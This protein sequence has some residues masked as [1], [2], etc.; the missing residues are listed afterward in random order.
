MKKILVTLAI[1]AIVG[2][3]LFA[4][5]VKVTASNE[6]YSETVYKEANGDDPMA[7]R[8]EV[9]RGF[10]GF[11]E[12]A[13]GHV[14]TETWTLQARLRVWLW[15]L[16]KTTNVGIAGTGAQ[17]ESVNGDN[18]E[19]VFFNDAAFNGTAKNGVRVNFWYRPLA[20]IE[21]GIGN[22]FDNYYQ[23]PAG[24]MLGIDRVMG[25]MINIKAATGVSTN[26]AG[27]VTA[28]T[29]GYNFA[30]G[31]AR[32]FEGNNADG[33][34]WAPNGF[35]LN[36]TKVPNL[37][38]S[39]NIPFSAFVDEYDFAPAI[40]L[41]AHYTIGDNVNIGA[42]YHGGINRDQGHVLGAYGQF[43]NGTVRIPLGVTFGFKASKNQTSWVD[44]ADKARMQID[45]A[46]DFSFRN[47]MQLGISFSWAMMF[48]GTLNLDDN[49]S[50][51]MFGQSN[52]AV[53]A[54]RVMPLVIGLYYKWPINNAW[55]F[56]VRTWFEMALGTDAKADLL[57][58]NNINKG[59]YFTTRGTAGQWYFEPKI[60]FKINAH[61]EVFA[62]FK[63]RF[64]FVM[65]DKEDT[66]N[67]YMG[68]AVPIG[69]KWTL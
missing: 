41:A 16:A 27:A 5:N 35:A 63:L 65:G 44:H 69:W 50:I 6:I 19:N 57:K 42:T 47:G 24:N 36:I 17:G 21:M 56:D 59:Y 46:P 58:N 14:S 18:W 62:G 30:P 39:V 54:R 43:N 26:A 37:L 15:S 22:D 7:N 13:R 51:T 20:G 9:R 1:F 38:L 60:S 23:M 25:Y 3:M 32:I 10:W 28:I 4:Q 40:N 45:L 49:D 67:N 64:N 61:N 55:T 68:Y 11:R 48:G 33:A 2:N 31:D 29:G 12:D 52:A 66:R 53:T 34:R 8:G